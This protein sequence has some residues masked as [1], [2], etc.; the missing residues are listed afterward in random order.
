M[1]KY[2]ISNLYCDLTAIKIVELQHILGCI[3]RPSLPSQWRVSPLRVGSQVLLT[4]KGDSSDEF[5]TVAELGLTIS[6][7]KLLGLVAHT[8]LV[9]WGRFSGFASADSIE[10]QLVIDAV[11]NSSFEIHATDDAIVSDLF[12]RFTHMRKVAN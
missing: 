1:E 12:A 5:R 10:P 2:V 7:E 8:D 9:V 6:A 4:T 11:D 3:D